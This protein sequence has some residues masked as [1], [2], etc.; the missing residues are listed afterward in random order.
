MYSEKTKNPASKDRVGLPALVN[1][2]RGAAL[3][4]CREVALQANAEF[5][6]QLRTRLGLPADFGI[7]ATNAPAATPQ[8]PP[9]SS[10][11]PKTP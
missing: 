6:Q 7:P 5:Q 10:S 2:A 4:S 11:G 3:V 1:E 9:A 8:A